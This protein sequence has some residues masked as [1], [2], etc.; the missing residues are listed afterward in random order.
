MIHN[1]YNQFIKP[2]SEKDRL[3]NNLIIMKLQEAHWFYIDFM[4]QPGTNIGFKQFI[5]AFA[6][7]L[8]WK[9]KSVARRLKSYWL[10]SASL[11]R[12]GGILLNDNRDKILLVRGFGAKRWTFPAGK[13]H[14]MEEHKTC[15]QREVFEETGFLGEPSDD[16]IQYQKRKATY[17]LYIFYNVPEEYDFQPQTRKEI[18]EI[19]WFNVKDL[20][21]IMHTK[22]F[23]T[24]LDKY[25]VMNTGSSN[26]IESPSMTSTSTEEEDDLDC[27]PFEPL[28]PPRHCCLLAFTV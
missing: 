6:P 27:D 1:L 17:H 8:H 7:L 4:I 13:I 2:L 12:G 11:P 10:Y 21:L 26:S 19:A 16:G 25:L 5:Y 20:P 28:P 24:Q 14:P 18:A 15:A 9:R 22:P 23:Q 3:N